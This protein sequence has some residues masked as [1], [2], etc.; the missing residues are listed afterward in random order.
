[1][2]HMALMAHTFFRANR[3]RETLKAHKALKAHTFFDGVPSPAAEKPASLKG[4][5]FRPYITAV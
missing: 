2:A 3:Q 1:M 5:A 4:T